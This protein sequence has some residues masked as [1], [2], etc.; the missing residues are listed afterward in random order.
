MQMLSEGDFMSAKINE[1]GQVI[2]T[3]KVDAQEYI[4]MK[5]MSINLKQQQ[6]AEL[7][8]QLAVEVNEL[9]NLAVE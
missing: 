8:S 9:K 1:E 6:I 2:I 7:Q 5:L 4:N 3:S